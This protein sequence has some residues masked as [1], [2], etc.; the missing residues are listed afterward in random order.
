VQNERRRKISQ[1]TYELVETPFYCVLT[2]I[3]L[4]HFWT[5]PPVVLFYLRV[6]Q[7]ALQVSQLKRCVFL[8]EDVHTFFILSVWEGEEGFIDF[9]TRVASHVDA[10][11]LAFFKVASRDKK[12]EIWSAQWQLYAV[13]NNLNWG[14][15]QDW[16][17]FRG[18]A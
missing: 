13:S 12:P 16:H 3:R 18:Q 6:R 8:I 1:A 15:L 9:G 5:L 10:A 11:A 7:Q 17:S 14:G 4:R 2:R